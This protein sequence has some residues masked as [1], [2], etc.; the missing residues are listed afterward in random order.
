MQG[1]TESEVYRCFCA[2]V[3][4]VPA[5][6]ARRS[7]HTLRAKNKSS[8]EHW[9]STEWAHA[10]R[11][12]EKAK[13]RWKQ[14]ACATLIAIKRKTG[15]RLEYHVALMK[16][17]N[18]PCSHAG[19]RRQSWSQLWP[20]IWKMLLRSVS[21]SQPTHPGEGLEGVLK[22]WILGNQKIF[23]HFQN[24]QASKAQQIH[25]QILYESTWK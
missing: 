24:S 13:K 25:L 12:S 11:V 4:T 15:I 10:K 20:N 5:S 2:S 16:T 21:V 8:G 9:H 14:S 22:L 7:L 19:W 18:R 23:L 3:K 6:E 17:V 1:M